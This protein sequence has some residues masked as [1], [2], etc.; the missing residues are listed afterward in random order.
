M[1][2]LERVTAKSTNYFGYTVWDDG[3]IVGKTGVVLSQ[4]TKKSVPKGYKYI[5]LMIDGKT[6]QRSVHSVVYEAF[7]GKV[8]E[9][10]CIDHID[11]NPLNNSLFNLQVMTL[12]DNARKDGNILN[13][14]TAEVIRE[15]R[16]SG[17][18][19]AKLAVEYGISQQV[20]CDIKM[21]RK[22]FNPEQH[23]TG[24]QH[25]Q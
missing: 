15:R 13:L 18:S 25:V 20:V 3:V 1:H 17:E 7:N 19:G 4:F 21:N 14:S 24:E 9:G 22:W 8:V 23:K 12:R 16:L 11:N 5:S 2:N 6:T 10:M